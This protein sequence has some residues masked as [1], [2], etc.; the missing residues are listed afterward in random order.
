MPN[1]TKK[2]GGIKLR[3]CAKK[4]AYYTQQYHRTERN[5]LRRANKRTAKRE[6]WEVE[7]A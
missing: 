3:R 6:F 2:K 4:K 5:K 1:Q 7:N